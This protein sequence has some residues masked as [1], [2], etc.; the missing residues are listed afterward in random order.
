MSGFISQQPNGLYCR[1]SSVVDCITDHNMT[2]QDY[3]F[4]RG[5]R[6]A[7]DI[8]K[9]HLQPFERV[10]EDFIA[11]NMTVNE[12]KELLKNMG[13]PDWDKF[14]YYEDDGNA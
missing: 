11:N 7:E 5:E 14:K 4:M 1:H 3:I 6:E 8:F 13:D 2:K 9:N 12:F 10:K